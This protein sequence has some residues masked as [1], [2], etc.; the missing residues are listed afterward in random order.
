MWAWVTPERVLLGAERVR[1][2][3][4]D[5]VAGLR[6]VERLRQVAVVAEVAEPAERLVGAGAERRQVLRQRVEVVGAG[7]VGV[8]VVDL[9]ACL[10]H[11][12]LELRERR[13]DLLLDL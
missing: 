1:E 11:E 2:R 12:V 10:L 7:V 3:R 4:L 5:V 13:D 6:L 9:R 8:E